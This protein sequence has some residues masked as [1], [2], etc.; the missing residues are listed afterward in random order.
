MWSSVKLSGVSWNS[1]DEDQGHSLWTQGPTDEKKS[2]AKPLAFRSSRK[3]LLLSRM[4]R[5]NFLPF[6]VEEIYNRSGKRAIRYPEIRRLRQEQTCHTSRRA[7]GKHQRS[8]EVRS[9]NLGKEVISCFVGSDS[10]SAHSH[11][12]THAKGSIPF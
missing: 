12:A 10:R 8:A 5:V 1:V 6:D 7:G 9:R 3:Y 4:Q 11:L 2:P